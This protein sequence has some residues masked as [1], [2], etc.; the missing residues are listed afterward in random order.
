[1]S[2]FGDLL[3]VKEP[4]LI[5]F[6]TEWNKQCKDMVGVL[7]KVSAVLGSKAKIV[8]IDIEKNRQ[9]AEAL[10]IKALPTLIIYKD[11]EMKWRHTGE[12]DANTLITLLHDFM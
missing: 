12:Q 2:K 11:G 3:N 8:K 10:R 4:L 5:D 7:D 6:Y 1:M 9:L